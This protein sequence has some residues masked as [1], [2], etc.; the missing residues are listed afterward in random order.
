M[1]D[2]S[3]SLECWEKSRLPLFLPFHFKSNSQEGIPRSDLDTQKMGIPGKTVTVQVSEYWEKFVF[4]LS[5]F[6]NHQ[7][8]SQHRSNYEINFAEITT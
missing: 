3:N 2:S 8:Y 6:Q 1:A 5:D 4:L 7:L